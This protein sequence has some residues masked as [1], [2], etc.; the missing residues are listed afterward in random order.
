MSNV[1]FNQYQ[2]CAIFKTHKFHVYFVAVPLTLA[3]KLGVIFQS[4]YIFIPHP[5]L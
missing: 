5:S 1:D 4:L 2:K 3:L